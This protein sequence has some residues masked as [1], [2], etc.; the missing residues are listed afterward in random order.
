MKPLVTISFG[1]SSSGHFGHAVDLAASLPGYRQQG[2]GQQ[3]R[4]LVELEVSLGDDSWDKLERLIQ[5]I[6]AWRSVS[7]AVDGRIISPRKFLRS[8]V[9]IK[10]C[11]GQK[12]QHAVGDHYCSGKTTPTAEAS[13]FGC[14]LCRRVSRGGPSFSWRRQ[15]WTEWG[16]LSDKLDAFH[17]DK[18]AIVHVLQQEA[19]EQACVLCPAFTFERVRAN[20]DDLPDTIRLDQDGP[21]EVRFSQVNPDQA[22]GIQRKDDNGLAPSSG[23]SCAVSL[24]PALA[25]AESKRCVPNVRYADIAG[26]DQALAAIRQIVQLPLTHFEYFAALNVEPQASVLLYGPPGNGK[27]LLAKAAATES[28]AHLEIINGPEILSKW[29]GE[30]EANLRR[31]FANCRHL[32]PSVLLIDELDSLAPCRER[33]SQQHDVQLISQLLVLLDGL[34]ARG[35]LAVIATTNRLEAIDPALRRPGRFDYHIE[36]PLPDRVGRTAILRVHLKKMRLGRHVRIHR[37]VKETEG[38]SGAALAGL[39]R[40]AG[41][42]A[43]LRA[44]ACGTAAGAVRV[45]QDDLSAALA[46]WRS[47]R[48]CHPVQ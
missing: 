40:E 4:H 48:A 11:Y 24:V 1:K 39:C 15:P 22:L 9:P 16:A 30:S 20:V 42:Q 36:V 13:C 5:L 18:E 35:R 8:V 14:R 23:L 26:Q 43:I 21:Y 6:A 10:Q 19:R 28:Q 3:V 47:K 7:I 29:V 41:T 25:K 17:V 12:L 34:E 45:I 44:L 33:M 31:I 27:T 2:Q 38:F 32:A 37:L 46:T